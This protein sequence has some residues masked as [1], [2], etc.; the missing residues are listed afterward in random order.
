[1]GNADYLPEADRRQ[2]LYLEYLQIIANHEPAFFVME[3][4]KGLLSATLS[5]K[6]VFERIVEDLRDPSRALKRENRRV[7]RSRPGTR[8]FRLPCGRRGQSLREP[9]IFLCN[10]EYGIPQARHRVILLG[11]MEGVSTTGLKQLKRQA[12]STVTEA[13]AGLPRLRSGL[14][15]REV[16]DRT[17]RAHLAGIP[18]RSWFEE[19]DSV[20]VRRAILRELKTIESYPD[21]RGAEFI[22][23]KNRRSYRAPGVLNHATRAH[24]AEDLDRYFFLSCFALEF[25]RS[26]YSPTFRI[27]CFRT[28]RTCDQRQSEITFLIAFVCRLA[29]GPRLRSRRTSPKTATITCARIHHS[30]GASQFER[31]LDFRPSQTTI[32]SAD[33][34]L[35]S[36]SKSETLFRLHWPS[37]SPNW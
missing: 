19:I 1:M 32:S 16:P 14:T 25:G 21:G 9:P 5:S 18:K 2:T 13:I 12:A 6:R 35:R 24:I 3:N 4:V 17:W 27:H 33:L 26:R 8:L 37:R 31:P 36:T 11:V 29:S 15:D 23:N 30:A 10:E 7:P 34:G 28:T 20:E 22:P